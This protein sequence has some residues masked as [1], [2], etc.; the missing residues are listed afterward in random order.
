MT[1][2]CGIK[3]FDKF[4]TC[5]VDVLIVREEFGFLSSKIKYKQ[6]RVVVFQASCFGS[7]NFGKS[8]LHI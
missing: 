5:E 2:Q 6:F 8:V 7:I 3:I 4:L 1:I